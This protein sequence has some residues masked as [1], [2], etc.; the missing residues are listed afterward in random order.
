MSRL[1]VDKVSIGNG[2]LT[3]PAIK[4]SNDID[5][6]IYRIDENKIGIAT[7]GN[8]VGEIGNGYGGF[9]GNI[10]Q[11]QSGVKSDYTS[12]GASN[13]FDAI[14]SLNVTITPKYTTSKILI[15]SHIGCVSA[16]N[17][18]GASIFRFTRN[19]T[20]VGISDVVVGSS[21]IRAGFRTGVAYNGDHGLSTS[22]TFLDSPSSISSLIYRVEVA[23]EFTTAIN[24]TH[25][26]PDGVNTY[27]ARHISTITVMELQQ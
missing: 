4:F 7:N 3:D 18:G 2:S 21:R 6:G 25:S 26:N 11:V 19:G 10:I 15:I 1:F 27:Q 12:I 24:G 9:T 17:S 16:S 22:M 14:P 20:P 13:S 8:R 5:T 23:C